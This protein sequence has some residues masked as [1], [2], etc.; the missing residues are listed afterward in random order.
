MVEVRVQVIALD[1]EESQLSCPDCD[2]GLNLHQPDETSPDHLLAT[3][4]SCTRWFALHELSGDGIEYA[5]FEIPSLGIVGSLLASERG[6][7]CE[8]KG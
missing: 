6:E 2:Q 4:D 3:C 1:T 5:M 8:V 7:N